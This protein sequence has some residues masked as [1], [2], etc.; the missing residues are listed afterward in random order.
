MKNVFIKLVS[1]VDAAEE[2]IDVLKNR[3]IE[4]S[5]TVMQRLEHFFKK[6]QNIQ[7]LWAMSKGIANIYFEY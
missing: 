3:S 5:Q 7:Q 6:E 4:I 1:R 2:R